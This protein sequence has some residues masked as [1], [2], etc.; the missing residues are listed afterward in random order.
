VRRG[1]NINGIK[2]TVG[3]KEQGTMNN[4]KEQRAK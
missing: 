2:S 4:E 3:K 1:F